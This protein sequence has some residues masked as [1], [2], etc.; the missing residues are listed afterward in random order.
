MQIALQKK[1]IHKNSVT[2]Q[3][4]KISHKNP[5]QQNNKRSPT[6]KEANQ[7]KYP[8]TNSYHKQNR[9]KREKP[10]THTNKHEIV[11]KGKNLICKGEL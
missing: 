11:T 4:P 7:H 10:K 8:K 3:Q 6:S 1:H 5:K 2:K 9:I